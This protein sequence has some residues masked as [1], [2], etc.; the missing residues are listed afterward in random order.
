[1]CIFK[2]WKHRELSNNHFKSLLKKKILSTLHKGYYHFLISLITNRS[3]TAP[4]TA[5]INEPAKPPVDIPASPNK[6][7]PIIAPYTPTI[8]LIIRQKPPPHH[9]DTCNPS[10]YRTNREKQRGI[11]MTSFNIPLQTFY[12]FKILFVTTH[13]FLK[14]R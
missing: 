2:F 4:A 13:H 1:M 6:Y 14:M 11:L 10:C 7:P 8:I 9:N 5:V 3:A 12:T